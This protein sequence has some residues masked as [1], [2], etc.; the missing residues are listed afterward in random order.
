MIPE[1]AARLE[2]EEGVRAKVQTENVK[3]I[4]LVKFQKYFQSDQK[5]LFK[6]PKMQLGQKAHA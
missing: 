6:L 5:L 1:D 2:R 3:D 4:S